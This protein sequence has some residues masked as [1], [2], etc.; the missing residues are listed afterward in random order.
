MSQKLGFPFL[1]F[2]I[3]VLVF[4]IG[5]LLSVLTLLTSG[6]YLLGYAIPVALIA[7]L[8]FLGVFLTGWALLG[9]AVLKE[10]LPKQRLIAFIFAIMLLS[11]LFF[12]THALTFAFGVT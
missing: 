7:F 2:K 8:K 1:G 10:L 12:A 6:L 11:V 9:F 4:F 3:T 5:L